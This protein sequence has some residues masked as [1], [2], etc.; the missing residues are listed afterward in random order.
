[1]NEFCPLSWGV[2]NSILQLTKII[3]S[4]AIQKELSMK[5][6]LN[7]CSFSEIH[8]KVRL[9]SIAD[10]YLFFLTTDHRIHSQAPPLAGSIILFLP[11]LSPSLPPSL[12]HCGEQQTAQ[13]TGCL[14]TTLVHV[15]LLQGKIVE[16]RG[17]KPW[18][19]HLLGDKISFEHWKWNRGCC[20]CINMGSQ[21][22]QLFHFFC[23][24]LVSSPDTRSASF[25]T[26]WN[27]IK[28]LTLF[29]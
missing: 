1:M 11:I 20:S 8:G 27:L 2:I 26:Y 16:E 9:H 12:Y 6:K 29:R 14:S 19:H 21:L 23:S 15:C 13:I 28:N 22:H 5:L 3:F 18:K 24:N 25:V 7:R 10:V 4:C 17:G